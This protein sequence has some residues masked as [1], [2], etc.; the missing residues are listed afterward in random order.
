MSVIG[1]PRAGRIP[2]DCP[3]DRDETVIHVPRRLSEVIDAWRLVYQRYVAAGIIRSHPY[4]IHTAR[5]AI[6]PG[7]TVVADY[8]RL[9]MRRTVSCYLDTDDGLPLDSVYAS[10]LDGARARGER[11]G[12]IGLLA[13]RPDMAGEATQIQDLVAFMRYPIYAL[14]HQGVDRVVIGVHPRHAGFYQRLLGFEVAAPV[15]HYARLQDRP[16]VLLS[17]DPT[18]LEETDRAPRGLRYWR[19]HPLG[20]GVFVHRCRFTPAAVASSDLAG[21]QRWLKAGEFATM[22]RARTG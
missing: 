3:P 12:E 9:R 19:D 1:T 22:P 6:G 20:P 18:R 15:Q 5:Q 10:T 7:T 4:Q 2:A 21:Y 13:E 16:V 8:Q 14:Y 17:F 11:L